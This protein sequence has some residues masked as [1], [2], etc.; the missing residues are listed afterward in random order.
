MSVTIKDV[1]QLANVAP[2]T[3]SRVIANNP[4]ISQKT[5]VRVRE[6]M[7]DLGYHPNFIARSL[8]NQSTHILGLVL[9]TKSETF[10]TTPIFAAIVRGL[11]EGARE[12][13]YSLLMNTG[14]SNEEIYD[15]VVE[16]VQGGMVDG[17]VLAYSQTNDELI[18]YLESRDFP[19]VTIG[20]L[21]GSDEDMPFVDNDNFTAGKDVTNYLL[22]LGHE[23]IAFIGGHLSV[24]M[25]RDR[26]LGYDMALK[27]HGIL[28]NKDYRLYDDLI[29][30]GAYGV[31]KKM[32]ALP[33]RPTALVVSDDMISIGIVSALIAKGVSVPEQ[34]SIISFNNAHAEL[35]YPALTTINLNIFEL[36]YQAANSLIKMLAVPDEPVKSPVIPHEIVERDSCKK[37]EKTKLASTS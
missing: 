12:R 11:S 36:G 1:A 14:K 10:F 24:P 16:M 4:R 26:L 5:K 15:G 6:A 37:L 21:G 2:S 19:F 25:T 33:V 7:K 29:K 34:M 30:D 9:P 27:E 18:S 8:A 13:N 20:N 22:N 28:P 32:L 17:I 31:V 3:V 35:S 23:R